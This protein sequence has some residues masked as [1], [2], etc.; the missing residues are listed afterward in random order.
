MAVEYKGI[1]VSKH[2]GVIDFNK[3][4]MQG[5]SFVMIRAGF[6]QLVSQKDPKFET[7]Y[8]NAV[9]A[10][11]HVGAYWYSYATTANQAALEADAFIKAIAGKKF[12]YPVAFDIE[13]PCQVKL[14]TNVRN[15]IIN[16]FMRKMR[17]AGYYCML[18]SYESFFTSYVSRACYCEY[19][20]WCANTSRTPRIEHGMHQYSFKGKV[21]GIKGDV[22]LDVTTKNYPK[23]IKDGGYNGYPKNNN[24]DNTPDQTNPPVQLLSIDEIAKEVIAGKWGND[25]ERKA[26]LT[27]AGYNYDEVQKRVNE[28]MKPNETVPAKKTVEQIAQECIDG[29]WG[30]GITRKAKLT[31][32]GYDAKAVQDKVNELLS[33]KKLKSLD[34]IAKEVIAGKWGNGNIRKTKLTAAGYNY[35]EVQKRVTEL[36]KKK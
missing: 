31:L 21:N 28:L 34:E 36:L 5:Y 4:V 26:K 1:D 17:E 19:D 35:A 32:A 3:V 9:N 13:D 18:Y 33:K 14:S 8:A 10:G 15:E 24:P 6:G 20:I 12:D 25:A 16:T 22:D 29:M 7:N 30:N 23:I 27:T 2:N 11:L